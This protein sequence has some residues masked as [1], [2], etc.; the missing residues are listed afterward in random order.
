MNSFDWFLN[1][2]ELDTDERQ[3]AQQI[4]QAVEAKGD[5]LSE[6]IAHLCLAMCEKDDRPFRL[7]VIEILKHIH[8][9][10]Q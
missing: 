9:G 7:C 6:L 5:Q 3:L 8:R 10:G 2:V 4:E 1:G